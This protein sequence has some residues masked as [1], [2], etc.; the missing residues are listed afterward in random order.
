MYSDGINVY[1][2]NKQIMANGKLRDYGLSFLNK[3]SVFI[4]LEENNRRYYYLIETT[5]YL[6][7]RLPSTNFIKQD[8]CRLEYSIID[9]KGDNGLG[10]VIKK[11]ILIQDSVAPSI[12]AVK[13]NN[14]IDTW[15]VVHGC[16]SSVFFS[17][18]INS[19]SI[20]LENSAIIEDY[21]MYNTQGYSS[22]INI[23]NLGFSSKGDFL[24]TMGYHK[25]NLSP[26]KQYLF[27]VP[28]DNSTGQINTFTIDTILHLRFHYGHHLFS[29]DSKFI[30]STGNINSLIGSQHYFYVYELDT[31]MVKRYDLRKDSSAN[32]MMIDYGIDNDIVT[33]YNYNYTNPYFLGKLN[34][35]DQFN[36]L[37]PQN[38]TLLYT[39][40]NEISNLDFGYV[41]IPFRNNHIMSF[42]HPSYQ[43]PP[44]TPSYTP[45]L[46]RIRSSFCYRDVLQLSAGVPNATDSI[47]WQLTN[48][49]GFHQ[50]IYGNNFNQN[51][52][53]GNYTL[54][55]SAY[56]YCIPEEDSISFKVDP[57]PFIQLTEDS[58]YRCELDT[59]NLPDITKTT[60]SYIWQ[61]E[62]NQLVTSIQTEGAYTARTT[63]T[64]GT[65]QDTLI[66]VNATVTIPNLLTPNGD[67]K[68]DYWQLYSNNPNAILK[69]NVYNRWGAEVYENRNYQ[70]DW[71]PEGLS[72]GVY[73][74][75]VQYEGSC[76]KRGWMQV[77]R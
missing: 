58:S 16:Y 51:L 53:P 34:G 73:Y 24:T 50:K 74:Y 63:N 6:E 46:P 72:D 33:V 26:S 75:V 56:N 2:K 48:T 30:Y 19:C 21:F 37:P 71:T 36:T 5:P 77:I 66:V 13:H 61:N 31:K 7:Y 20:T 49:K 40:V 47:I 55:V 18:K 69:L 17:Y 41:Y 8:Y 67:N 60:G 38:D 39:Y 42:Y 4:P 15:L 70:N 43:R 52:E 29:H 23:C 1:N 35:I 3:T 32:N 76:L 65:A 68:N 27:T 25:K 62:A 12:C 64:C 28:F 22:S 44:A 11:N 9:T 54:T 10:E 57:E 14:N 59:K 45:N